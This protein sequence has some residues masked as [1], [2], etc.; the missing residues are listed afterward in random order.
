[1]FTPMNSDL[2][3]NSNTTGTSTKLNGTKKCFITS[4]RGNYSWNTLTHVSKRLHVQSRL[5]MDMYFFECTDITKFPRNC[6]NVICFISVPEHRDH[7]LGCVVYLPP[8]A[9]FL[10]YLEWKGKLKNSLPDFVFYTEETSSEAI[11][12]SF[13]FRKV[14]I[15]SL[16]S[17]TFVQQVLGPSTSFQ[18]IY[19]FNHF[20]NKLE[21][22]PDGPSTMLPKCMWRSSI[23]SQYLR[24]ARYD[25]KVNTSRL[26]PDRATVREQLLLSL[27][28][29]SDIFED[30]RKRI[31]STND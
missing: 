10:Y 12:S 21:L 3:R 23:I 1:M 28:S 13:I 15:T 4:S 5:S 17:I 20:D 11:L 19:N 22:L 29:I 25:N 6:Q 26:T 31:R 9:S 18:Y 8:C 2:L 27:P 30:Y 16:A 14:H 24:K 7:K